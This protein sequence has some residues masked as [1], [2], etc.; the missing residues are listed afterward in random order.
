MRLL[1]LFPVHQ[2]TRMATQRND[3]NVMMYP[4]LLISLCIAFDSTMAFNGSERIVIANIV[5][6]LGL[7]G[8]KTDVNYKMSHRFGCWH[9]WEITSFSIDVGSYTIDGEYL[10]F[11]LSSGTSPRQD[12]VLPQCISE[13]RSATALLS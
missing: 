11:A 5:R 3:N 9:L 1:V 2:A 4:S 10:S 13:P 7:E 6:T 8:H 12:V